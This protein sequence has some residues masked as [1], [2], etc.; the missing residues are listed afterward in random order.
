[1]PQ[2]T[3]ITKDQYLAMTPQSFLKDGF[4]NAAGEPRPELN[5]I[6]ATAGAVQMED[7]TPREFGTTLLAVGQVLPLHEDELPPE[8]YRNSVQE[9]AE[10][11]YGVLG[12]PVSPKLIAWL[13]SFALAIRGT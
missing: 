4:R 5:S 6:W 8:R 9:A 12:S 2:P 10:V 7:V 3:A 13:E 1:M 11:S